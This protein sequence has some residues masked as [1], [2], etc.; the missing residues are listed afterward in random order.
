M[1][2]H[3]VVIHNVNFVN[4]MDIDVQTQSI[5]TCKHIFYDR[6]ER[7]GICEFE[8]QAERTSNTEYNL[9]ANITD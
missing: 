6:V 2:L 3:D 8:K 4:P 5:H 7:T 9:H 1:Y